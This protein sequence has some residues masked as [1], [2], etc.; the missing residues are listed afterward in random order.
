MNPSEILARVPQCEALVVTG[1]KA[2][3]TLQL[4]LPPLDPP[5]TGGSSR[6]M[7]LDRVFTLYR[8]PSSSRAYPRPVEEKAAFYRRMF[9]ELS[10]I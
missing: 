2:L 9:E 6:F 5:K 8:M 4:L 1:Q 3:D 10:I 7:L